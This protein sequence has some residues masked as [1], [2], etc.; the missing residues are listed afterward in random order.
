MTP[1]RHPLLATIAPVR[2]LLGVAAAVQAAAAAASVVPLIVLGTFAASW[3]TLGGPPSPGAPVV[4]ALGSAVA[5]AVLGALASWLAHEADLRLQLDLQRRLVHHLSHVPLG[6]LTGS[7]A[8]RVTK[9]V[10]DDVAALHQLVAHT[11]LDVTAVVVT[12]VVGLAY[13][14]VVDWRLALA[15]LV[16]LV[17]G[18]ALF[19]RALAASRA[20]FVQYARAQGEITAATVEYV[21]G[22]AVVKA[23]GRAGSAQQAFTRATDAFHDFFRA[24]SARTAAVTTASWLVV[25]PAVT[26]TVLVGVGV[27]GLLAGAVTAEAVVVVALVG[28]AVAAPVAVVGPRLQA[29]RAGRQAAADLVALLDGAQQ[30]W[31]DGASV[32]ADSGIAL[33]GVTFSYTDG[34]PVL[35]DVTAVLPAGSRTALVGPSGAGK[36]TLASLLARFEDPGAGRVEIGGVD[37]R[38]LTE[39]QL[40][41]TVGAVFQD[42]VLLRASIR[43]NLT[44]GRPT[45]EAALVAATTA[46]AVHAKIISLERGY[47]A[48]VG[49]DVELSGGEAQRLSI[50]RA[51]LRD[52]PV[53]VLDEATSAVDPTTEAAVQGALAALARGRT[54]V[55]IAHRLASTVDADQILVL[56]AGAVV[57]RGTHP[58]LVAAG[59]RYARMWAAQ[60][61]PSC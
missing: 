23:F 7:G 31:G 9:A 30:T 3:L 22:I 37:L 49:V 11:A 43:D 26:L 4:L 40:H 61:V 42:V 6:D 56:D 25:A 1:T 19:G 55:V 8:G 12:P 50:A 38:D 15:A 27:L 36:S 41:D 18:A 52:T 60:V 47:D 17:A 5:G 59:G 48:V 35:R 16:P 2:G 24:W 39:E 45:P 14:V 34:A 32:P 57:E 53:V 51:L 21:Q 29:L 54:V 13:L 46:A 10:H 28:P 44:G 20:G 33:E 58:Q